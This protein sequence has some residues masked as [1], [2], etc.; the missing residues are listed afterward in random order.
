MGLN[1]VRRCERGQDLSGFHSQIPIGETENRL[2]EFIPT[3]TGF[4]NHTAHGEQDINNVGLFK[5]G[6]ETGFLAGQCKGK[7]V[8]GQ[9]RF[10]PSTDKI[11]GDRS[12]NIISHWVS[13]IKESGA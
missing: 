4:M 1:E 9:T 11:R 8:E 13:R 6:F 3:E 5:S 12:G 7:H 10:G 2:N